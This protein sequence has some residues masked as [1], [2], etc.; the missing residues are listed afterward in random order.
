MPRISE[1]EKYLFLKQNDN[2]FYNEKVKYI[3]GIDEAGRGPLA[4]PVVVACV[5]LPKDSKILRSKWFKKGFSQKKRRTIW[6]NNGR[7]N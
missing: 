7:S 4:G 3:A 2:N 1:E 6:K 5:I